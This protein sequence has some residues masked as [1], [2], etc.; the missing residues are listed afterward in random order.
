[1][2]ARRAIA[3]LAFL[4]VWAVTSWSQVVSPL[5]LPH[6]F[7]VVRT[8]VSASYLTAVFGDLFA[9]VARL[10][11]GYAAGAGAGIVLGLLMGRSPRA[12]E[13]LE[14]S[15]DFLR[16]IPVAALFPL[17]IVFFGVGDTSKV[18]TTIW[19]T[20]LV[21]VVNTM[22]GVRTMPNQR[23]LYARTLGANRWQILKT[24]VVPQALPSILGAL[25]VGVAI[26]LIVTVMTEMFLGTTIGL[27]YRIY[28]AA[29]LYRTAELYC[30]IALTGVLGYLLNR[31]F[32]VA[33]RRLLRTNSSE[34]E[35]TSV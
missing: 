30:A 29:L 17:F 27:G 20:S 32:L 18:A 3:P 13:A 5:L 28:N 6:P 2:T 14:S 19:S 9:T 25:R 21:V 33:E 22:Y 10:V 8:L 7:E 12:Y 34:R 24:V 26:A 16:S 23:E 15:I 11:V 1:M 35:V 31:C 4:G